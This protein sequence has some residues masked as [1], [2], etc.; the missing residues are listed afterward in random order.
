MITYFAGEALIL[1]QERRSKASN[2]YVG[3]PK[4]SWRRVASKRGLT[5]LRPSAASK[6]FLRFNC[7]PVCVVSSLVDPGFQRCHLG[8]ESADLKREVAD[9]RR[10]FERRKLRGRPKRP[11]PGLVLGYVGSHALSTTPTL[12]LSQLHWRRKGSLLACGVARRTV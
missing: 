5:R 6:R 11:V 4:R 9:L 8:V 1:R 10:Y 3:S 12:Y 7:G 2:G